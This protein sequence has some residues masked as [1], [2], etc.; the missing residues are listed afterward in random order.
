M[1]TN[2]EI[3]NIIDKR[4]KEKNMSISELARRVDMAKSAVSRY[5]NK[6][7]E[8]PLNRTDD[9]A[10]VLGLSSEYLLGLERESVGVKH[11]N[12][13][14]DHFTTYNFF[15]AGLSAGLLNEVDPFTSNDVETIGLSDAIMGKYAG[16]KNIFITRVNGESM[17]RIVPDGSII[18]VKRFDDF[19]ELCNG[20]IV[21]FQDGSGM[22][23]KKFFNDSENG[24]VTLSPDSLNNAFMPINYLYDNMGNVRFI[25][26]VVV[27]TVTV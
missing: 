27:Y 6:T 5:L 12:V 17:N 9:F 23:V 26:K 20:D 19:S 4:R 10:R 25:G 15:D 1:R 13:L 21:V 2:E 16:D 22:A 8:F 11:N 7:R 24:I 18:A 14:T 3:I